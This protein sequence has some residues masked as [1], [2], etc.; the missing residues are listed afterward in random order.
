MRGPGSAQ[1][2]GIKPSVRLAPTSLPTL[3]LA[4]NGEGGKLLLVP[5]L[6]LGEIERRDR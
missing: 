2:G 1:V 4:T 5:K 6:L 3:S